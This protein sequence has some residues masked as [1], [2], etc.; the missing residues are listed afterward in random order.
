MSDLK[1]EEIYDKSNKKIYS[2]SFD[3]NHMDFKVLI[4]I[5]F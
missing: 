5:K 3:I 2:H 1:S 4:L